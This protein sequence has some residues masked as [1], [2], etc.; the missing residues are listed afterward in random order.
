ML[1]LDSIVTRNCITRIRHETRRR[2]VT[3]SSVERLTPR[4]LR[5]SFTGPD[6]RDFVSVSPDDHVKLF[7]NDGRGATENDRPCMRDYTPRRFDTEQ[8]YLV[9]DFALH[10]AGPATTWAMTARIGDTLDIGGP[11]GSMVIADDFDWYVFIGDETAL[12]AIGRF[13]EQARA[14][15]SVTTAVVVDSEAEIQQFETDAIWKPIWA[16]RDG[17]RDDAALLRAD[18]SA[19]LAS[20][21]AGFVW[22]AAEAHIARV[23]RSYVIEDRQHPREWTK[24]AGYWTRGKADSPESLES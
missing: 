8:C 7:F 16:I 4:M 17:T 10:E 18:L 6:L 20:P 2:T 19:S 24:A 1:R 11:R 12:P 15:V 13:V 21:G 5:V 14:G 3:V 9:I 22:I 23:L